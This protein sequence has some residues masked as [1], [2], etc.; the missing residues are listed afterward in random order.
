[1]HAKPKM[2]IDVSQ[3]KIVEIGNGVFEAY[4]GGEVARGMFTA[5]DK[6]RATRGGLAAE[7]RITPN[8][9]IGRDFPTITYLSKSGRKVTKEETVEYLFDLH[10]LELK[11]IH[12][13]RAKP[14]ELPKNKDVLVIK[15]NF[16]EDGEEFS[17]SFRI[18]R[19]ALKKFNEMLLN[20][21]PLKTYYERM[22]ALHPK[23]Y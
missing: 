3:Y 1:M 11:E 20:L 12:P 9:I 2:S 16:V 21:E 23:K 19:S 22:V 14:P 15:E 5:Q 8:G 10:T 18:S 4:Y 17:H 13:P 6:D 7:I